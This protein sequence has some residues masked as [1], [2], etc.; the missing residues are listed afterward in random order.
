MR[1]QNATRKSPPDRHKKLGS[2]ARRPCPF[3]RISWSENRFELFG[4]MRCYLK[5]RSDA[6]QV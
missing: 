5:L 1:F 6:R 4:L 3:I 2:V